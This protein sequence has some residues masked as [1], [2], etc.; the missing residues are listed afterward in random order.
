MHTR[1][2]VPSIQ[3]EKRSCG[4]PTACCVFQVEKV[5]C[6]SFDAILQKLASKAEG[7]EPV[8]ELCLKDERD[9]CLIEL[10]DDQWLLLFYEFFNLGRVASYEH[11]TIGG[12][13]LSIIEKDCCD[14]GNE[15]LFH[16]PLP[17]SDW[18][19]RYKITSSCLAQD[20][21]LSGRLI[22]G[23]HRRA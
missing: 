7:W 20:I 15:T 21:G 14:R 9:D 22:I 5:R 17:V 16:H 2:A 3:P 19:C 1:W 13:L 18:M 12:F 4:P 11:I 10:R 8:F 23:T 6:R